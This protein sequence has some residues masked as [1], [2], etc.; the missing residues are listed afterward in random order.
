M[1]AR[2]AHRPAGAEKGP[3]SPQ[4]IAPG[5]YL[6]GRKDAPRFEGVR[7]CV[8]DE[9]PGDL[10]PATH[11]PVYDESADRPRVE[12]L[13]RLAREVESARAAGRPVLI[14]C[15]HGVRRSPLAAAWYLHRYQ[16]LTLDE[17]YDR[18][19]AVRPQVEH[20]REW[21]GDTGPLSA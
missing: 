15:G 1:T 13:D 4:E 11:L 17:A 18:I 9:D 12:N 10:P 14:F 8:L 7:L 21:I 16:H 5:V 20:A 2:T 3:R 19:R 6:G